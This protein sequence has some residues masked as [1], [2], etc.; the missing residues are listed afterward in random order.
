MTT[1]TTTPK[2][3]TVV[4]DHK[5]STTNMNVYECQELAVMTSLYLHNSFS[6]GVKRIKVTVEAIG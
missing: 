6:K 5:K 3:V 4:M 1:D 2:V